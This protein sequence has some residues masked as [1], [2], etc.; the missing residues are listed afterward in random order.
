M[1]AHGEDEALM[2]AYRDGDARA[3]ERLYARHKGP[4][5]RYL[6]RQ[7]GGAAAAEELFQDV[8]LRVVSARASYAPSAKFTTWL[9]TIAHNRL[10]DHYRSLGR[11]PP[12]A[13]LDD[14]AA[15]VPDPAA[16]PAE[17]PERALDRKRAAARI[18]AAVE[19]LPD[20]QREAFL[21]QQEGGLS[22]EEI[23]A[24][25]GVP[26]ETAKSRLRYALAKL[27]AELE[28]VR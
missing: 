27:R 9:Y 17:G 1:E 20:A 3:F 6:R 2:L 21:L 28:D 7:C 14:A 25:T 8:W 5:F 12:H 22:V 13:S 23:A 16:D 19:A 18:V 11:R 10:M 15:P 4:V 26:F 24:A